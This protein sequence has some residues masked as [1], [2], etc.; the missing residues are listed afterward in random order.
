MHLQCHR[1]IPVRAGC[2]SAVI[3][4]LLRRNTSHRGHWFTLVWLIC[5][6]LHL[7]SDSGSGQAAWCSRAACLAACAIAASRTQAPFFMGHHPVARRSRCRA[8]RHYSLAE[9]GPVDRAVVVMAALCVPLQVGVGMVGPSSS[10]L[11]YGGGVDEFLA[12]I[13]VWRCA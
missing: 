3:Q 1:G 12:Q 2:R 8:R 13:V 10:G 11:R 7:E 6:G 4:S 5:C 9:L